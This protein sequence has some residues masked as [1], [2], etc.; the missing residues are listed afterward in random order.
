MAIQ[1]SIKKNFV[2]WNL[3][4]LVL[5]GG[6]GAWGA[7]DYWVTIPA[8]EAAVDRYR[9]L[10]TERLLLEFRSDYNNLLA[11][12]IN[13]EELT[14]EETTRLQDYQSKLQASGTP[15][16][17]L[18]DADMARYQEILS[19]LQD[20]FDSTAPQPP[21]SYDRWV[22]IWVYMVGTGLLGTPYFGWRL[23]SRRGRTWRLEDDGSFVTPEGTYPA[24]AIKDIDMSIW[25][26][27]SIAKVQVQGRAEP[28]VLDDYEYQDAYKIIGTLA[29]QFHPDEWTEDAKPV[30][31]ST[32][33][34]ETEA[35][36]DAVP[37]EGEGENDGEPQA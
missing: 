18:S 11:K 25:M 5:C 28:V 31:E 1:T 13:R 2:Y 19:T 6:L 26:K 15:A 24:D 34:A 20:E 37:A 35:A 33:K 8:K 10:D 23:L 36:S 30:K 12:R 9:M 22:Q 3:L 29:H 27:K 21:A 16:P 17:P 4:Y 14:A 32:A 7:Y